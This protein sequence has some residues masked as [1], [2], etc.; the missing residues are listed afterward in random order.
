[1][2]AALYSKNNSPRNPSSFR[3]K[4]DCPSRLKRHDLSKRQEPVTEQ[5]S[6]TFQK[7][8][9][10][11]II[12]T[13]NSNFVERCTNN[14]NSLLSLGPVFCQA[15]F[16]HTFLYQKERKKKESMLVRY[17]YTAVC[18]CVCVCVFVCVRL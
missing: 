9:F 3:C 17:T 16:Q 5:H 6:I 18:L 4:T 15:H 2:I 1:M 10:I 14:R 8:G 7:T 12:A 11:S 13:R